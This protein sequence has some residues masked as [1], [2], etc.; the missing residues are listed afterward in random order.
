[1]KN[2]RT[3]I[4]LIINPIAGMGGAVGLKGTDGA[5]ILAEAIAR[6]AMPRA[7]H[8]AAQALERLKPLKDQLILLTGA[9]AMGEAVAREAGFAV[10]VVGEVGSSTGSD[11]TRQVASEMMNRGVSL[12]LF[13]GG[14]GTA[15]DIHQAVGESMP[16]LGIPAGVKIHSAVFGRNPMQAGET[17]ALWLRGSIANTFQAEVMDIN[18]DDYR[19]EVLSAKL[20]GYLCIPAERKRLQRLKCG[21]GG[22]E[23]HAQEAMAHDMAETIDASRLYLIGAGSTTR[24]FMHVLG[25]EGSLLGVDAVRGGQLVGRDMPE[26]QILDLLKDREASLI[27]TPIGG[28]GY[29]LGR[30]NLQLS[31]A[32]L[33]QL[34]KECIH[35]LAT[36]GKIHGLEG[37]P[38]LLDS[39]DAR[40]DRQLSGHYR[41]ITGYHQHI[42]YK[43]TA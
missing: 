31:P 40:L 8:R 29:L 1:M 34:K 15:R 28:Q 12:L 9:E 17:A 3:K 42:I 27:I 11:D 14:D 43:V 4:G 16:V 41:I 2:H 18:E 38:L 39:G 22:R 23:Q 7:S 10:E 5:H 26:S 6:G 33:R 20:Y 25:L 21:S 37:A 24:T 32:V 13:A 19:R 36:P 30:G 35:V